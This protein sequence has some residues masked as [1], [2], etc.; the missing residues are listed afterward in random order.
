M[1]SETEVLSWLEKEYL[2]GSTQD[3]NGNSGVGM[4]DGLLREHREK[5]PW[6]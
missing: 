5:G 1:K 3:I 6:K 4:E 2:K